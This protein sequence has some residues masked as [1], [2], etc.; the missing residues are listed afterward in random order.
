MHRLVSYRMIAK[1]YGVSQG[2]VNRWRNAFDDFP[3]PVAR[4]H[5]DGSSA[6]PLLFYADEVHI[7]IK[8]HNGTHI[9]ASV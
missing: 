9:R 6:S 7:W 1:R 2:A 4:L 8:K 5:R 3:K